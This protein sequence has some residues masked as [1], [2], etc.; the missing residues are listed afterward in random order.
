MFCLNQALMKMGEASGLLL[1]MECGI[2]VVERLQF[3]KVKSGGYVGLLFAATAGLNMRS[4]KVL[5]WVSCTSNSRCVHDPISSDLEYE[6]KFDHRS[7][8]RT[9]RCDSEQGL[10]AV[11]QF[12]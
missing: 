10:Y 1:K 3:F 7:L 5:F 8:G 6:I 12:S 2:N 4:G 9:G 11:S